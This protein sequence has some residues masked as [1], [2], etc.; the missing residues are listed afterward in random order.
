MAGSTAWSGPDKKYPVMKSDEACAI[1]E[2]PES[3]RGADR[4]KTGTFTYG[5]MVVT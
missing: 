4:T 2:L 3:Y 5:A 1:A